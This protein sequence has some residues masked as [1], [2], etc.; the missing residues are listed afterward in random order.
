MAHPFW[1]WWNACIECE[2]A[3]VVGDPLECASTEYLT[4][5]EIFLVFLLQFSQCPWSLM[6]I[7]Q[8]TLTQQSENV[9]TK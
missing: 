7:H 4:S 1:T 9:Q 6:G 2:C 3:C 8:T 5:S